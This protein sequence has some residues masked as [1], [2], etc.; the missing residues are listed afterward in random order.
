VDGWQGTSW[1]LERLYANRFAR[2]EVQLNIQN[3][4]AMAKGSTERPFEAVILSDLEFSKLRDNPNYQH[5]RTEGPV[6]DIEAS[7]VVPPDVS[8]TLVRT[9]YPGA[10]VISQSQAE[11]TRKRVEKAEAKIA[12]L[13][14]AKRNV[15]GDGKNGEP[16]SYKRLQDY[17]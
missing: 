9:D 7:V 13:L 4:I 17:Y 8:G 14:E 6:R 3:N 12:A 10:N 16:E 2:P 5:R 11:V 1:C 15:E